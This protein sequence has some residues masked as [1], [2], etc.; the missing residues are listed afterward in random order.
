[1]PGVGLAFYYFNFNVN[2]S[3]R[4]KIPVRSLI[5]CLFFCKSTGYFYLAMPALLLTDKNQKSGTGLDCSIYTSNIPA[6]QIGVL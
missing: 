1:M 4:I 6:L 5:L 2:K 3:C